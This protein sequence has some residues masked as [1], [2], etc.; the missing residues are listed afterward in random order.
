LDVFGRIERQ[1]QRDI[2]ARRVSDYV[3]AMNAQVLHQPAR[4][5]GVVC[6][7]DW[8]R[9]A[10]ATGTALTMIVHEAIPVESGLL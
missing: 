4:V 8:S 3:R 9:K 2:P 6:Q 7:A 5:L 10:P 1:L